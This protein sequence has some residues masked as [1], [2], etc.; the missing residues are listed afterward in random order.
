MVAHY[1]TDGL[2]GMPTQY[3]DGAR[4]PF[5][6]MTCT[7]P[8]GTL[9][10]GYM[11]HA[12]IRQKQ[13]PHRSPRIHNC[14]QSGHHSGKFAGR[15]SLAYSGCGGPITRE[16]RVDLPTS[17]SWRS[18]RK[19]FVLIHADVFILYPCKTGTSSCKIA[20]GYYSI[21]FMHCTYFYKP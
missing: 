10:L 7:R 21:L 18:R 14:A 8:V 5:A 11:F 3:T 4:E 6:W 13:V 9:A 19:Y 17:P 20:N 2:R 15:D 16:L 1:A 12:N